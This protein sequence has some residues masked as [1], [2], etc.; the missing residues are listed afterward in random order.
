[1]QGSARLVALLVS[2]AG[3]A[4]GAGCVGEI[5]QFSVED[6][7]DAAASSA[8]AAMSVDAR[9][10]DPDAPL[11]SPDAGGEPGP[12][13][14]TFK[15]TYYYV[16]DENDFSGAD[17][18]GIYDRSCNLL[19]MVP[20]AFE[21]SLSIEGTGRLED[22]RVVNYTGSCSCPTSPCYHFVDDE[23]P[24][25]S[26]TGSRP[27]VPFR[28]IAIDRDVLTTGNKYYVVELDGVLMPGD[29]TVGGFVHDGCVSAD[30]TGGSIDDNHIDF[31]AADRDWYLALNGEL[32][33][34]QVTLREAGT[35]CR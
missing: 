32:R 2:T 28:S 7:P 30:D 18:T 11:P 16:S 1:M 12:L 23:H 9:P 35:W 29:G 19:A 25:G 27:L 31:F 15:L 8:D 14:G 20:A 26:G 21:R 10:A 6:K 3:T 33:L 5:E 34:S 4:G 17:D 24:W 22:G 13:I